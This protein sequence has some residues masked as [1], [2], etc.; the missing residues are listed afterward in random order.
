[1]ISY[2]DIFRFLTNIQKAKGPRFQTIYD[3]LRYT[4]Y[5]IAYNVICREFRPIYIIIFRRN[6]WVFN[7][8]FY[9]RRQAEYLVN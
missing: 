6:V 1:M 8:P 3:E 4:I 2:T 7:I 5:S 9:I